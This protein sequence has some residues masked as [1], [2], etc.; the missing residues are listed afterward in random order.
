MKSSRFSSADVELLEATAWAQLHGRFGLE[1]GD[2]V[3]S[4]K[5]IGKATI[6]ASGAADIVAVNRAIGFG[7]ERP[8]DAEQLSEI[9]RFYRE[10]G[11][12]RWFLECSP[13]ATIDQA[14]VSAAGGVMGHSLIKLV[15]D[16]EDLVAPPPPP[17]DIVLAT[18]S[19]ARC[20]MD[21]VGSQLGVPELLRPGI[22]STIGEPGWYFHFAIADGQPVAG[23]AMCVEG[24]GAWLGL[25][26][27]LPEYRNRGAQSALLLRRMQD[28]KSAGAHW[29]SAEN[30]PEDGES[31]PSLRNMTRLGLQELYRRPWYRFDETAGTKESTRSPNRS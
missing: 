12:T 6:L 7:F 31:N 28:A 17:I 26:G 1:A 19:D 29:L 13:D 3:A 11:K 15:A 8:L 22:A 9:R 30:F 14:A 24:D 23:A 4:V 2:G 21:L 18:R 27:T 25:A 16:L 20:F 10:H 5:R